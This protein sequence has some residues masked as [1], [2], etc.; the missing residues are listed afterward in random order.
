[1]KILT[2]DFSSENGLFQNTLQETINNIF[3][4]L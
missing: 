2:A 1:M 3:R 4:Y